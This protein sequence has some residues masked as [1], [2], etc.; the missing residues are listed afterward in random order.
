MSNTFTGGSPVPASKDNLIEKWVYLAEVNG[1]VFQFANLE[2][3]VECKQYF[4]QKTHPSTIGYHP[5]YEHYWQHW[6]CKLPKGI[7][8]N[9]NRIK[10]LKA[11]D[12]ILTEWGN[13]HNKSL[14]SDAASGAA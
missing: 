6:Y 14:K 13:P 7:T 9:K 8:K 1:F 5:P 2:Q 10:V 4:E 11:M 12:K 3:V